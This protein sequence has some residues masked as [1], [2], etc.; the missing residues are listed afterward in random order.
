MYEASLLPVYSNGF[1]S[2]N[3]QYLTIGLNGLNQAAEFLGI[4]CNVNSDY[5]D[6]CQTIFSI[7]KES[8]TENNGKYFGHKVIFNTECVPAE[9]LAA[10]NY[11]WDK[12]DG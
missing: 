4:K 9:S 3:K 2:L 12:A 11:N 1:I 8:N 10:K 6:F 7:I 5:K